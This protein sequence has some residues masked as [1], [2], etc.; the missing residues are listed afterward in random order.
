MITNLIIAP[1]IRQKLETKHQVKEGEVHECF[2][3]VSGPYLKDDEEDHQTSP[4][5]RMVRGCYR[6]G[7]PFEDHLC[8]QRREHLSEVCF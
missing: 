7:P 1:D 2:L 4:A 8:L 6:Q 3:N 5:F